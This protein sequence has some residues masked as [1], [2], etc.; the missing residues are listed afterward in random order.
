MKSKTIKILLITFISMAVL[1]IAVGLLKKQKAPKTL[2]SNVVAS[3]AQYVEIEQKDNKYSFLITPNGWQMTSPYEYE[4]ESDYLNQLVYNLANITLSDILTK[5]KKTFAK[6]GITDENKVTVNVLDRSIKIL[7][8]FTVGN[9]VSYAVF[10]LYDENKKGI[11][12]GEGFNIN[13]LRNPFD[14]WLNKTIFKSKPDEVKGIIVETGRKYLEI[15]QKKEGWF[16]KKSKTSKKE[17][18]ISP[19]KV[20]KFVRPM[21]TAL[22]YLQASKV[23]PVSG[24]YGQTIVFKTHQKI[25]IKTSAK[26]IPAILTISSQDANK[27]HNLKVVGNGKVTFQ[28]PSHRL[29]HFQISYRDLK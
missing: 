24:K 4:A 7:S 27:N 8:K 5:D 11:R 12:Q 22:G 6:Y 25:E 13:P 14:T 20:T 1:A 18:K 19:E 15:F 3:L 26:Q 23:I 2:A 9:Q 29:K 28:I 17:Y 16:F 21:L 10:Y